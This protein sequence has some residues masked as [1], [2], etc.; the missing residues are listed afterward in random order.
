M[1]SILGNTNTFADTRTPPT[2]PLSSAKPLSDT[3]TKVIDFFH[4]QWRNICLP[5][6]K[7]CLDDQ[8]V[9]QVKW[10]ESEAKWI[11]EI[12]DDWQTFV[13]KA[14]QQEFSQAFLL[15]MGKLWSFCDSLNISPSEL[16]PSIPTEKRWMKQYVSLELKIK[17]IQERMYTNLQGLYQQ[18]PIIMNPHSKVLTNVD[19]IF[20]YHQPTV[21]RKSITQWIRILECDCKDLGFSTH[22]IDLRPQMCPILSKNLIYSGSSSLVILLHQMIENPSSHTALRVLFTQLEKGKTIH[23]EGICEVTCEINWEHPCLKQAKEA[24]ARRE[25]CRFNGFRLGWYKEEADPSTSYRLKNKQLKGERFVAKSPAPIRLPSGMLP[26]NKI[27]LTLSKSAKNHQ[28]Y[29]SPKVGIYSS[30]LAVETDE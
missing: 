17:A 15:K 7:D 13:Y 3:L 8:K 21:E 23:Q 26:E 28:F 25:T 27:I 16:S 9:E 30:V 24:F 12:S 2:Y 22:L 6:K 14:I 19:S 4:I 5:D 18:V 1:D 20:F 10:S 29:W 11:L